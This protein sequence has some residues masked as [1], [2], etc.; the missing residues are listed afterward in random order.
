MKSD[1]ENSY[2]VFM[3]PIDSIEEIINAYDLH[4]VRSNSCE[5]ILNFAGV[6]NNYEVSFNWLQI[7]GLIRVNTDLNIRIPDKS[8]PKLQTLISLINE[9]IS[10]GYF[11]YSSKKSCLYFR[12]NISIKGVMNLST[13]QIEDFIDVVIDECD[14]Y[15]PAFHLFLYKKNDPEYAL[16]HS[17]ME[18]VGEA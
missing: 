1:S 8:V 7:R 2:N 3:N 6:W 5:L 17:F 13:E 9:N 16:K 4:F 10:F 14:K 18:T 12:H 11:G 15:F